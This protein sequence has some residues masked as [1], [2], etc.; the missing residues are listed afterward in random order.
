MNEETTIFTITHASKSK[1]SYIKCH[2]IKYIQKASKYLYIPCVTS[3]IM[4]WYMY[5]H[6]FLQK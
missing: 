4:P 2:G 3:K 6:L 1:L 5:V